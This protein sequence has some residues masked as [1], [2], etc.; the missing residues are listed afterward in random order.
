MP[1]II[2]SLWMALL[3]ISIFSAP[4][5][6][7]KIDAVT[8]T[9]SPTTCSAGHWGKYLNAA[10][11]EICLTGRYGSTKNDKIANENCFRKVSL[12]A[13]F[14]EEIITK[15]PYR[16]QLEGSGLSLQGVNLEGKLAIH[17]GSIAG[18]IV[19]QCV[20]ASIDIND[21][22]VK[23]SISF[24]EGNYPSLGIR[25][26]RV[27]GFVN[28]AHAHT[29]AID[30]SDSVIDQGVTI[31]DFG[32]KHKKESRDEVNLINVRT[33][34][35]NI[36]RNFID[37]LNG[38]GIFIENYA[39]IG[40]SNIGIIS[41]A[42]ARIANFV[43]IHGVGGV[44]DGLEL[45]MGDARVGGS[46]SIRGSCISMVIANGISIDGALYIDDHGSS[47]EFAKHWRCDGGHAWTESSAI[48]LTGAHV[49]RIVMT[50]L[51]AW[52]SYLKLNNTR[53][54][55]F[56]SPDLLTKRSRNFQSFWE[57]LFT[58]L[59]SE[60]GVWLDGWLD[61]TLSFYSGRESF[62]DPAPFQQALNY[63]Q[64]SGDYSALDKI[65][66]KSKD[67]ELSQTCSDISGSTLSSCL[68]LFSASVLGYGRRLYIAVLLSIAFVIIGALI[69]RNSETAYRAKMPLSWAYSFDMFLP[70]VKL[71]DRH[72]K[73]IDFSSK[74]RYYLY[75]H[76]LAGWI[77]GTFIVASI[78]SL[79][80]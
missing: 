38:D 48:F 41:M 2:G 45:H 15:A 54:D 60:Q 16:T 22:T 49:S 77:L 30:L 52:P 80:K 4:A 12:P 3:T 26:T 9:L 64:K 42:N 76:K 68:Y 36:D 62:Y 44:E 1:K 32:D 25:N 47:S 72:Y 31:R 71:R 40:E 18:D 67:E 5:A 19:F 6:A 79:T 43:D 55:G 24:Y 11:L 63:L 27:Q 53:I 13:V 23:G 39:R 14:I 20:D 46:L 78:V 29:N 10:W 59:G 58:P 51:T 8:A 21:A 69:F 74:V 50:P 17:G 65:Y 57:R 66:I 33:S 75:I 73:D 70:L 28:I 61:R 37:R 35:I 56:E 7:R 34:S